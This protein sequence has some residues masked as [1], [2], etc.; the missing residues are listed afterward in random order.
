MDR[1]DDSLADDEGK[2]KYKFGKKWTTV[3]VAEIEFQSQMMEY[4][5]EMWALEHPDEPLPPLWRGKYMG[6]FSAA[7]S[8]YCKTELNE[9]TKRRMKNKATKWNNE[10]PS[11]DV[12]DR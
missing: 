12:K 6:L 7:R 4:A 5:K 8:K 3:R 1:G 10:G 9:E 11:E 2:W